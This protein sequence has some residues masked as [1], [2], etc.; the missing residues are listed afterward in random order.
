MKLWKIL[1]ALLLLPVMTGCSEGPGDRPDTGAKDDHIWKDQ[2]R[3]MERARGVESVIMES[4][5]QRQEQIDQR[6]K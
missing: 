2:T 6:E 4:A 1:A 3:A 5:K